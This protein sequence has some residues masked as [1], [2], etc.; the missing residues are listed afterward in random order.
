MM[1]LNE[2]QQHL[3][4]YCFNPLLQVVHGNEDTWLIY[5][6]LYTPCDSLVKGIT[7]DEK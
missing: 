5:E 2:Q 4:Q 3:D 6:Y 1:Q 7:V